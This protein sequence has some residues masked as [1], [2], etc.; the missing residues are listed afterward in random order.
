MLFT[1]IFVL[2]V[3]LPLQFPI[4]FVLAA[5]A[6]FSAE[7]KPSPE[8][9]VAGLRLVGYFGWAM[10]FL[11]VLIAVGENYY[12]RWRCHDCG[13]PSPHRGLVFQCISWLR[14]IVC[15][16]VKVLAA[17]LEFLGGAL[18]GFVALVLEHWRKVGLILLIAVLIWAILFWGPVILDLR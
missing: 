7:A 18:N 8:D 14:Q 12:L 3:C 15:A 17:I 13:E 10:L 11:G 2:G 1:G 4:L 5:F 9:Y 6:A 16:W